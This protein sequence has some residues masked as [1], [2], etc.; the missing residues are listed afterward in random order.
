MATLKLGLYG[1]AIILS[2]NFVVATHLGNLSTIFWHQVMKPRVT[3]TA[4]DTANPHSIM[5][6]TVSRNADRKV[7]SSPL[8]MNMDILGTNIKLI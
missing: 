4:A 3:M 1:R 2:Y 5:Q 7:L 8:Y 6:P